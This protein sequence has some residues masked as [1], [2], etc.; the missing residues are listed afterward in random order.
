MSFMLSA[1][2]KNSSCIVAFYVVPHGV[3]GMGG[4][5]MRIR[6]ILRDVL[7]HVMFTLYFIYVKDIS[8]K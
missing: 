5:K 1:F 6:A 7:D 2:T 4:L 8:M 3:E